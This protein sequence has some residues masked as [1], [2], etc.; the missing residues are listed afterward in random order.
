M[1]YVWLIA[2]G[3]ILMK[4]RWNPTKIMKDFVSRRIWWVVV[5]YM[6]AANPVNYG[7]P[8]KLN[9]AEA[10][11]GCLLFSGFTEE[12][13]TVMDTFKWGPTFFTLN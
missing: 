10:L 9:C 1:G 4:W 13:E 8:I 12:A 7:K 3:S 2:L 11:A 5:P 6:L